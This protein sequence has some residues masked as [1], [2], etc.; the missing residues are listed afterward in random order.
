M[1]MLSECLAAALEQIARDL[2]AP[3][4]EGVEYRV[5]GDEQGGANPSPAF[6]TDSWPRETQ[7]ETGSESFVGEPL[8]APAGRMTIA[9]GSDVTDECG[10]RAPAPN[11]GEFSRRALPL[12]ARVT[13]RR[14]P[15]SWLRAA[16]LSDA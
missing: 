2:R 8:P 12:H 7:I 4:V 14:I 16:G 11:S 5:A 15:S 13:H 9:A 3:R 6:A 1:R 10:G